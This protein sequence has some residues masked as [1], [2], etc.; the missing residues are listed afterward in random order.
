[1]IYYI[2]LSNITTTVIMQT[3]Y[4]CEKYLTTPEN[5]KKTVE[6]Y[7]VAIIPGVLNITECRRTVSGIW[8]FFEHITQNW[9][10]P[11]N[12]NKKKKVG[13]DF[14]S[15]TQCILCYF[16]TGISDTHKSYGI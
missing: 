9:E 14:T 2:L 7:G 1:M 10:T 13:K 12:R 4:E 15:Y 8:D 6:K 5:L 16:S 3:P 11:I